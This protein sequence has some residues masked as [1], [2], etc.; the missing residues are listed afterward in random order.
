MNAKEKIMKRTWIKAAAWV[1]LCMGSAC[2][3]ASVIASDTSYGVIDGAFGTVTL[4]VASHGSISDLNLTIDFSKCDDP[5]IGPNRTSCIGEGNSF[6]DEIEFTLTGPTGWTVHL[7]GLGTYLGSQPGAGR[8]SVTFDDQAS[9]PVGGG[10]A[11]GSFRP[12]Q[13]LIAFNGSDMFGDWTLSL[14]DGGPGD[15]LEYF[16]SRLD[17]NADAVTALPEPASAAILGLGLLAIG[18]AR[19]RR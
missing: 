18:M 7:V 12:V 15:P 5:P 4:S 1:T 8:V 6:E 2:A 10:T 11:S 17:I 3:Q 9:T 14:H 13:P 16:G 19:R